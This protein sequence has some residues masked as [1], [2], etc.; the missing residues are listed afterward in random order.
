MSNTIKMTTDSPLQV[1]RWGILL[2]NLGTPKTAETKDVRVYLKEFLMDSFVLDL[3]WPLR[4]LLVYGI[5]S[6]FR[7]P[8]SA[9]LYKKIWRPRGSPL[10]I[11]TED[12]AKQLT[13]DFAEKPFASDTKN[14][15]GTPVVWAFR[16]GEDNAERAL[17]ELKRNKVERIL[18]FPMYP[19]YA[20]SATLTSFVQLKG[21]LKKNPFHGVKLVES[22]P[23]EDFYIDSLVD[24]VAKYKT[25]DQPD[26]ILFSFHSLPVRHL[27]KASKRCENCVK[28]PKCDQLHYEL[29]YRGQSYVTSQRLES[30]LKRRFPHW[31]G[32]KVDVSFQSK[33]TREPWL[34]PTTEATLLDYPKQGLKNVMVLAPGFTADCLETLEELD[35][36]LK[37]RFLEAG[38]TTFNRIPCLN[39][40]IF[41]SK[42]VH[43][44]IK[45]KIEEQLVNE[46]EDLA[47]AQNEREAKT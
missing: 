24:L 43:E 5:I 10:Q 19:Q 39:A 47:H 34:A 9:A 14:G 15:T 29:C 44:F 45:V 38:G 35:I 12:F 33:L 32:I 31:N 6:P 41:W 17:E 36:G 25:I 11:E 16:Y 26:A 2:L 37:E 1:S 46:M 18:V 30:A 42:R 4:F 21:L 20:E 7:S 23:G 3:P 40:E 22:Y 27:T 13:R 8:K 28:L